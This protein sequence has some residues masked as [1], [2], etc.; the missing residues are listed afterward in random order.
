VAT[1]LLVDLTY[2]LFDPRIKYGGK[3]RHE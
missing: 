1:N 2:P 3:G